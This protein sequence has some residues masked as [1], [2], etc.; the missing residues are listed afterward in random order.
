LVAVGHGSAELDGATAI[1]LWAIT[2]TQA[3]LRVDRQLIQK[4]MG[5]IMDLRESSF[6]E[7]AGEEIAQREV[8]KILLQLG[9]EPDP[10]TLARLNAIDDLNRLEEM[11]GRV[12]QVP[13][14]A[15]LL[16]LPGPVA[17]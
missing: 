11:A 12:V 6:F 9:G 2:T 13:D 14:W 4:L 5:G 8:R 7:F 10:S 17:P 16:S 3:G 15:S 1:D